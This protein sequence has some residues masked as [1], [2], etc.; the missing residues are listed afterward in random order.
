[1]MCKG[2]QPTYNSPRLQVMVAGFL[3]HDML[4]A[5]W[6]AKVKAPEPAID[7]VQ[8]KSFTVHCTHSLMLLT[9]VEMQGSH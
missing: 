2:G 5:G 7:R 9:N 8:L 1:M 3:G 4:S 6:V